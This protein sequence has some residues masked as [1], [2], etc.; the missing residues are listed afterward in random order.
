MRKNIL[1]KLILF[2][3]AFAGCTSYAVSQ[4]Y[5]QRIATEGV[6]MYGLIT[7]SPINQIDDMVPG[8]YKFGFDEKFK[9]NDNGVIFNKYIAGGGVYHNGKIYCNVYNDEANLPLQK[10]VWTI[11]DAETYEVLYEKELQDNCQ[12]TTTSLAYDITNNKIYGIVVDFT[13]SYLVEIDPE[14]GDMHKVGGAMERHLRFKTLVSTNNG[15]LY[16]TVIDT[17]SQGLDL[18]KIRKTDGLA[19]KVKS[20]T[21]K[22][23]LGPDDYL[24][25]NGTEQSLF[26]NRSTGK[27]YWIFESSSIKLDSNYTPI[28]EINLANAEATLVAY[29]SRSYQV[30]GA[31]LKEPANGAPSI[32]SDFGFIV[33]ETGSAN[34]HFECNIP[35]NDYFGKPYDSSSKLN[36]CIVENQDT[37]VYTQVNPGSL[38]KSEDILLPNDN[39][40]VAITLSNEKGN[41]PTIYRTFHAGFD[42]PKAPSNIRLTYEGLTTTLTWDAPTEGINGAPIDQ[43]NITYKV[44]RYPYEVV[45]AEN[46]KERVFTETHPEDMTRYVYT[47]TSM[48]GGK[49]GDWG[50]SNNLIIGTPLNPPYGG[51]FKGPEDMLNYYTLVDSNN[52]GYCWMY[53]SNTASA[54][55]IYNQYNNADDWMIAPPINYKKGDKY[56]LKFKAYS[57]LPKYPESLEVKFGNGRTPEEQTKL[58]IDIPEVP[59]VSEES[60]VTEFST[61]VSVEEDGIYYFGFHAKSAKFR[62]LLY[63]FDI[64]LEVESG[65][66]NESVKSAITV[67]TENGVLKIQNPDAEPISVIGSNGMLIDS[68]SDCNYERSMHPGMYLIKTNKSVNKVIVQ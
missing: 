49:E 36:L 31:W 64:R 61:P 25:N 27:V 12:C 55:Y 28:A 23:L 9:P 48:Y 3:S 54:V 63:V 22:N 58:L 46:L 16:S 51:I 17:K 24:A 68:F 42:L 44:I 6:E 7:F 56:T 11:L 37:L 47:V 50:F 2:V 65:I 39:H 40:K 32:V 34:G 13:D 45:V 57:S 5:F 18:Y 30:S 66:N 4:E 38:F 53:D 60:P 21:G 59:G 35:E 1:N 62:E 43:E 8:L 14:T 67:S 19:V 52:D 29:L 26:I 41:G 20:I 33:P 15:M 10:P